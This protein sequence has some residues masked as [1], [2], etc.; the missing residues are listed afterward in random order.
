MTYSEAVSYL[1][2]LINYEKQNDYNYNTS[3]KIKRMAR[4]CAL[5]GDPH[6]SI[7]SIH[8]AGTKG[9]GSTSAMIHSI[10][11]NASF[12]TGLYTSPH[13]SSF[14]ER[15]R[16]GGSLIS[17][18]DIGRLAE[19][20]KLASRKLDDK[21]TF[22]EA[23]TAIA[24]LYFSEKRVD[25]AVYEVGLGGRLDATNI[26]EPLVCAITPISYEHT[27]ILGSTL[28]AIAAEKAGIIKEGC[29]CVSAPQE[30]EALG[31]IERICREKNSKLILV[32]RDIRAKSIESKNDYEIFSIE[33]LSG[34]YDRLISPLI[35]SHQVVNAAVA[36][37]VIE[38]LR[39]RGITISADAVRRGIES[40]CWPGRMEIVGRS[41]L[42]I[43]DGAQNRASARALASA[44]KNIFKYRKMLLVLG[45]S[46]DKDV[47]GILSELLGIADEVILTKSKIVGRALEPS[48][49]KDLIEP[50]SRDVTL[51]ARV[52]D[53]IKEAYS[54]AGCDDLILVTGSLFVVGE[55]REAL[56]G[57][58]GCV[59]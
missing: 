57:D 58:A 39:L 45:V 6:R 10:L 9:K 33:G 17:E 43:V 37:G 8:V 48:K 59:R 28:A 2:S 54:R 40:T 44:V 35:G 29:P 12:N 4:L 27:H 13:L 25:F 53:A 21:I 5:L 14:R 31:V 51:T 52:K 30:D 18:N 46:K 24:Y 22:F 15:I 26:I 23:C 11:Q 55:A 47:K 38:A 20:V 34:D 16:V 56:M 50:S 7:N 19:K 32:G 42:V 1:N 36:I 3:F 49:I 41:P